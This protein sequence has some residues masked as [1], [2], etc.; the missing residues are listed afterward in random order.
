MHVHKV[1]IPQEELTP[2]DEY[3][4]I[5]KLASSL[6]D[7]KAD[8]ASLLIFVGSSNISLDSFAAFVGMLPFRGIQV[9]LLT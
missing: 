7:A 6:L 9:A 4:T 1:V 5:F 8:R 3:T 2:M